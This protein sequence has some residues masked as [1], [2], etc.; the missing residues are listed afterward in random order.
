MPGLDWNHC[1]VW[2]GIAARFGL[3]SLPGL[4]WNMHSYCSLVWS[5][6]E[7]GIFTEGKGLYSSSSTDHRSIDIVHPCNDY[8]FKRAMHQPKVVMGFLNTILHLTEPDK[9]LSVTYLDKELNSAD[10]LGR[11]FTVDVLCESIGGKRFLIEMQNDF[12]SDYTTKAFTEFSRLISQWD[13]HI[14]HQEVNEQTLKKVRANETLESVKEFWKDIHTAITVVITNKRFPE[15]AHKIHFT[16]Q[17]LM[18]PQIINTY[19]MMH[20]DHPNRYLGDMDARVV[21]V[22][23]AHFNKAEEQLETVEDK[24][25]YA[26]KDEMLSSGVKRIPVY[27]HIYNLDKTQDNGNSGLFDFYQTLNKE[28]VRMTGDLEHYEQ[29]IINVNAILEQ[30]EQKARMEGKAE[31]LVEGEAKGKAEERRNIAVKMLSKKKEDNE[32]LELSGLTS[33]ELEELK[34]EWKA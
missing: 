30:R 7:I 11:H 3:E 25:L 16:T 4:D 15:D 21:M 23:L 14:V 34:G 10:P 28:V 12:R 20:V 18:E 13:A 9:I 24:W 22:M 19:R 32:I 17:P 8:G 6:E 1:S 27:K 33:E 26:F 2:I 29:E 5:M 31:G